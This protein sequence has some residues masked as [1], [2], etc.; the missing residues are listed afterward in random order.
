MV[1]RAPQ[2][3]RRASTLLP[4]HV[5]LRGKSSLQQVKAA[6]HPVCV[7]SGEPSWPCC[8]VLPVQPWQPA[9]AH[10]AGRHLCWQLL[11]WQSPLRLAVSISLARHQLVWC[12]LWP[13]QWLLLVRRVPG[14]LP[15][16]QVT[17]LELGHKIPE[18]DMAAKAPDC[19]AQLRGCQPAENLLV[20]VHCP[21][22]AECQGSATQSSRTP[23]TCHLHA[24]TLRSLLV[25]GHISRRE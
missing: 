3:V 14:P 8:A 12:L 22:D 19:R 11:L 2:R 6:D 20:G 24:V 25:G 4:S 5:Q 16:L 23:V 1:A 13:W 18:Q 17:L 15:C 7:A 9:A 10:S 21:A